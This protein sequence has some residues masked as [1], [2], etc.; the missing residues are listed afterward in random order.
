MA[1]ISA[2]GATAPDPAAINLTRLLARLQKTLLQPDTAT[3]Q[4]LRTSSYER[5]RVDAVRLP[6]HGDSVDRIADQTTWAEPWLRTNAVVAARARY[7]HHQDPVKEARGAD[8]AT[9][10]AKY[11]PTT[12]WAFAGAWTRRQRWHLWRNWFTHCTQFEDD[13]E[14]DTS[15]GEDLLGED[16][17]SDDIE[18]NDTP[19]EPATEAQSSSVITNPEPVPPSPPPPSDRD[20]LFPPSLRSRHAQSPLPAEDTAATTSSDAGATS[21][22]EK[23]LSHNRI[24][25]ESL[26]SSLL[27]MAQALKASSQAFSNS[28]ESEK[29]VLGR[30]TEGLD[31][32]TSGLEAASKRMGYLRRMTEGKGWWGRMMMYAWIFGLMFVA[33][34][35]VGFLP[36]LRFSWLNGCW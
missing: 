9:P 32:N 13:A 8:R 20:Q 29:D 24:E 10:K 5:S 21:M 33:L 12:K 1:R 26:T 25:Q 36:K 23:M 17:P 22:T 19:S 16:T 6:L 15:E 7:Y 31:K 3:E 34:F 30:A 18:D 4:R 2:G 11:N 14:E 27:S 35:I 28:L